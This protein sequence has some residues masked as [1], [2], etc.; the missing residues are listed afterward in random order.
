FPDQSV[1]GLNVGAPVEFRG[2]V[3]GQVAD[4]RLEY[5]AAT[6]SLR[7]PILIDVETER[8]HPAD[9]KGGIGQGLMVKLVEEGLR[10][11]LKSGNLLTGQLIVSLDMH[12]DAP[13]AQL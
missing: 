7:I 9:A 3:I 5:D 4:V 8:I 1:R 11:Q 13:P 10:A 12:R 6:S 2:I